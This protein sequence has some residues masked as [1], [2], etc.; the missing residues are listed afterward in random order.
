MNGNEKLH[1][2]LFIFSFY[3]TAS[4]FSEYS[5]NESTKILLLSFISTD[6]GTRPDAVNSVNHSLKGSQPSS[7]NQ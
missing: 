6:P 1:Y 3:K 7:V 2:F 4:V 5:G